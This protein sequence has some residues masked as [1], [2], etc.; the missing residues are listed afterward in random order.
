VI[1][2]LISPVLTQLG[3][4]IYRSFVSNIGEVVGHLGSAAMHVAVHEG[5][6]DVRKRLRNPLENRDVARALAKSAKL[7]LE[8]IRDD[9]LEGV[10]GPQLTLAKRIFAE[11]LSQVGEK[12]LPSSGEAI[13]LDATALLRDPAAGKSVIVVKAGPNVPPT[14]VQTVNERFPALFASTFFEVGLK[15]DDKVYKVIQHDILESIRSA[16]RQAADQVAQLRHDLLDRITDIEKRMK[17]DR[18]RGPMKGLLLVYDDRGSCILRHRLST[19]PVTIGRG[20]ANAIQLPSEAV[21]RTHARITAA[22][23]GVRVTNLSRVR[24]VANGAP[25][26]TDEEARLRFGQEMKIGDYVIK[27]APPTSLEAKQ[28]IKT[29]KMA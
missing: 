8:Q 13:D 25:L 10:S 15:Q 4:T 21:S 7:A 24:I 5:Y 14:L 18:Q 2:L 12:L 3:L 26:A 28:W 23:M 16:Q 22:G 20:D 1:E 17:R 6:H 11:L 27:V 29:T 9:Y 19:D